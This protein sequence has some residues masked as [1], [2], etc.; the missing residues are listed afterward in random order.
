[1]LCEERQDPRHADAVAVLTP[2]EP[3]DRL[4]A[5]AQFIGLV[6]RVERKRRRMLSLSAVAI[7][8]PLIARAQTGDWPNRL[9][10]IMDRRPKI[11]SRSVRRLMRQSIGFRMQSEDS[12]AQGYSEPDL[13][14]VFGM[15]VRTP[16]SGTDPLRAFGFAES[17]HS[18]QDANQPCAHS[19]RRRQKTARRF[20]SSS[21]ALA[22]QVDGC[23]AS[24]AA[25]DLMRV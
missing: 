9:I 19:C 5:V 24:L 2:G 6:V 4:A 20:C 17:G 8:A 15:G 1:M 7:F 3:T 11:N 12:V 13:T 18:R 16:T 21:V 23:P 22:D 14:G 10:R 25:P